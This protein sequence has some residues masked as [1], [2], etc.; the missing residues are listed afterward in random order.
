MQAEHEKYL[1]AID[2]ETANSHPLSAC[3]VGMIVFEDEI[4]RASCRERV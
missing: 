1:I 2:F 3:Q 4:G